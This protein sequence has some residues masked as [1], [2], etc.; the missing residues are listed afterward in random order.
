M[1]HQ[2]QSVNHPIIA[3]DFMVKLGKIHSMMEM[4]EIILRR[5][6]IAETITQL[7]WFGN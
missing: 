4:L 1:K 5:Q 7:V 6:F 3:L 2:I